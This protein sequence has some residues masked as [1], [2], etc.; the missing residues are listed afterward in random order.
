VE[1]DHEACTFVL[2]E[3]KRVRL[4]RI[5]KKKAHI[6]ELVL[7]VHTILYGKRGKPWNV[8]ETPRFPT[9]QITFKNLVER[10][11]ALER[12]ATTRPD[13][14]RC[15]QL[16]YILVNTRKD[17]GINIERAD[18]GCVMSIRPSL[19]TVP[20]GVLDMG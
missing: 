14:T 3:E 5:R 17:A 12:D 7:Q 20:G 1:P 8:D 4:E 11:R 10:N 6:R 18:D 13:R 19:Q 2:Q 9:Q 16:P 15:L